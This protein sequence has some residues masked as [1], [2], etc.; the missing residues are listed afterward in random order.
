[1]VR[2]ANTT[3]QKLE[4]NNFPL[5]KC[6]NCRFN[7]TR[8]LLKKKAVK[9]KNKKYKYEY[10]WISECGNAWKQKVAET[11]I[12]KRYRKNKALTEPSKQRLLPMHHTPKLITPVKP[13]SINNKKKVWVP[14][15]ASLF[16]SGAN[17]KTRSPTWQS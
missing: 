3:K 11:G 14:Y 16:G 2:V 4:I 8:I 17:K 13:D 12:C 7:Q 5:E 9:L 6:S 15:K 1:M 10:K